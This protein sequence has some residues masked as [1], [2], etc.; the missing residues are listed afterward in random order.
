MSILD[1]LERLSKEASTGEW[2]EEE[3]R[4]D[5]VSRQD[6]RFV[7]GFTGHHN[8]KKA[9]DRKLIMLMR[10]NIDALI[11]VARAAQKMLIALEKLN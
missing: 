7:C 10:N 6:D 9:K 5:I 1:E 2:D 8:E 11:E 4:G 3:W